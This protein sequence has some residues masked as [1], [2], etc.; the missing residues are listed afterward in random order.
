MG[1]S[2]EL[3]IDNLPTKNKCQ[4]VKRN[5]TSSCGRNLFSLRLR[6]KGRVILRSGGVRSKPRVFSQDSQDRTLENFFALASTS[7]TKGPLVFDTDSVLLALDNCSSFCL[8]N[9]LKDFV[10]K[11]RKVL[12]DLLGLGSAQVY[13]EGTVR[14]TFKDDEGRVHSW[15]LPNTNISPD[16]PMRLFSLQHWAQCNRHLEAHSDTN[17]D[18]VT[19]E[20]NGHVRTMPLRTASGYRNSRK[21]ISALSALLPKRTDV[22]PGASNPSGRR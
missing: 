5:R 12:K 16:I 7:S 18:R 6:R 11:P 8:T 15:D 10:G 3:Y 21:A 17:G 20:W 19:L 9:N 4:Y 13:Y 14:W 2:I 22:F 1:K